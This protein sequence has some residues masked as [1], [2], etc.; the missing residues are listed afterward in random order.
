MRLPVSK[1]YRA[2]PELD[3]FT[4]AECSQYVQRAM[5]NCWRS[6]LV[7]SAIAVVLAIIAA[8]AGPAL[9]GLLASVSSQGFRNR[10][11]MLFPILGIAA[12]IGGPAFVAL[13]TRNVWLRR[14]IRSQL[15]TTLCPQCGYQLLGLP[16]VSEG[17]HCPECGKWSSLR[18]LQLTPEM[19]MVPG[20]PA[21][22]PVIH[23][24]TAPPIVRRP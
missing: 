5:K 9:V 21:R 16:L 3:R 20:S 23:P 10:Y 15:N 14:A 13:G 24:P 6:M 19:L 1:V 22:P 18:E 2:F 12:F 11:D 17:V 4:D 7:A 8:V